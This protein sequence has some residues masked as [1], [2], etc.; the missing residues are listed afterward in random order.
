MTLFFF[1][2]LF[3]FTYTQGERRLQINSTH[4]ITPE[5]FR[6]IS[7]YGLETNLRNTVCSWKHP[8]EYYLAECKKIGMNT[9]RIPV[10]IQY[11]V[12][13]NFEILDNIVRYCDANDLQIIMDF[14]RVSN[15]YQQPNPD[16]GIKEF[17]GVA[18]RDELLNQMVK[19]LQRYNNNASVVCTNSWNEVSSNVNGYNTK[20]PLL[21]R[22][23]LCMCSTPAW[24]PITKEIG[25]DSSSID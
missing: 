24:T 14:H 12:E 23:L 13:D 21:K 1:I 22:F 7:I 18:T 17:N 4:T 8:V 25:T 15:D 6:G 20:C 19:I 3:C 16:V 10:S 9:F 2:F 11:L 5:P